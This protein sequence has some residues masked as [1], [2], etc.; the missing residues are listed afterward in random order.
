MFVDNGFNKTVASFAQIVE[1]FDVFFFRNDCAFFT[2][3]KQRCGWVCSLVYLVDIFTRCG[4]EIPNRSFKELGLLI[5]ISLSERFRTNAEVEMDAHYF[6]L[7]RKYLKFIMLHIVTNIRVFCVCVK[8][9]LTILVK[10]LSPNGKKRFVFC[11]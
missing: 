2:Q 8:E 9:L 6:P 1:T 7:L 4:F 10:N 3:M 11:C 5:Q